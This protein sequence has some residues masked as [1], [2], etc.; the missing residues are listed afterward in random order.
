MKKLQK[1]NPLI[2]ILKNIPI[3]TKK[4]FIIKL[5]KKNG[6]KK[7][8]ELKQFKIIKESL[9]TKKLYIELNNYED[10]NKI[11]NSLNGIMIFHRKLQINKYFDKKYKNKLFIFNLPL[12]NK[13]KEKE[14][15]LNELEILF[16]N[17]GECEMIKTNK[18]YAFVNYINKK[19]S[20]KAIENINGISFYNYK[21]EV[22][23]TNK[24]IKLNNNI[25]NITF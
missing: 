2:L 15:I 21:I 13:K 23:Y 5:L 16:K 4:I 9:M 17:Q 18:N 11:Y 7:I 22:R 10:F 6:I 3:M 20:D 19:E 8:K 25:S 1:E 14:N 12:I 24:Q